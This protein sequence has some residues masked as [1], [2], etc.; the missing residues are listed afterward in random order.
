MAQQTISEQEV[1]ILRLHEA[2]ADTADREA[3]LARS[4]SVRLSL[5]IDLEEHAAEGS[6]VR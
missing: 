5:T 4:Q 2:G 6:W 1:A 3:A